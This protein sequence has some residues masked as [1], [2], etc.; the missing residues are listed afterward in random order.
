MQSELEVFEHDQKSRH[1]M[2]FASKSFSRGENK[3]RKHV[4]LKEMEYREVRVGK[5]EKQGEEK[6]YDATTRGF[7]TCAAMLFQH[8]TWHS[9]PQPETKREGRHTEAEKTTS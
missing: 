3:N 7:Y 6:I 1:L 5:R 8:A 9:E 2:L 4:N